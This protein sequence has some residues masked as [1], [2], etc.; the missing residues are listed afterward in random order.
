MTSN[1]L[2]RE[3][4][5]ERKEQMTKAQRDRNRKHFNWSQRPKTEK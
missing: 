1:G 3:G 2:E 5:T 4:V